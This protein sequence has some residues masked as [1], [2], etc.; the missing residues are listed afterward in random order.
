MYYDIRMRYAKEEKTRIRQIEEDIQRALKE[1][2]N[3][4]RDKFSNYVLSF[5][6]TGPMA[7]GEGTIFFQ[8][9]QIT[10]S[11]IDLAIVTKYRSLR[12][13]K[14]LEREIKIA[15]S[16]S[17]LEAGPLFFAPSI[18]DR[19][20]LLFV[21]YAKAGKVLFGEKVRCN[22]DIAVWEAAKILT[23]RCGAFFDSVSFNS[24]IKF[25]QKFPYAWSKSVMAAAEAMLVLENR[26]AFSI[27]ARTMKIKNSKYAKLMPGF[28]NLYQKAYTCRYSGRMP[29][30]KG[31][32]EKTAN[33]I[34]F[35]FEETAK[36]LAEKSGRD[37]AN[38]SA[39]FPSII[40]TRFFY[41]INMLKN[42]HLSIPLSE[43][44][45]K[46]FAEMGKMF[47]QLRSSEIPEEKTRQRV[48]RLWKHAERFWLPY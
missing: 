27:Q 39:P 20:D 10:G 32:I 5:G 8:Q 31:L 35:A 37:I 7:H 21:E 29:Q 41:F 19:P 9:D 25:S 45:V 23:S 18:F 43:P 28:L 24:G 36:K 1:I 30:Q 22:K 16:C 26:Y 47:G 14:A 44:L 46:E 33:F 40:S 42:E 13:Q 2:I 11:D 12:K 17:G 38:L 3:I 6:L 15:F 4:I 48:V 34:S